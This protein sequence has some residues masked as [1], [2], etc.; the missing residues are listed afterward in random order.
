[1]G[2]L[3]LILA[4]VVACAHLATPVANIFGQYAIEA[5]RI[6]F[7][8]SGF[9]MTMIL[10]ER[11]AYRSL[12]NFYVSRALKLLPLYWAVSL[13]A[14]LAYAILVPREVPDHP[15]TQW[16]RFDIFAAPLS[17]LYTVI[18]LVTLIGAD[19]WVWLGFNP[20]NGRLSVA[21]DY[22]T[23]MTSVLGLG[24]VPQAWTIGLELCFYVMAPFVV[25]RSLRLLC[26]LLVASLLCRAAI[27]VCGAGPPW[28]RSLFPAELAF[29]LAGALLYRVTVVR[30][31]LKTSGPIDAALGALSYP[32]YIAHHAVFRVLATLPWLDRL[33]GTWGWL[34]INL[35]VVA[36]IAVILDALVARPVDRLRARFGA[37]ISD[38]QTANRIGWEGHFREKTEVNSSRNLSKL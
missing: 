6:F 21:P 34:A 31:I 38:P 26:L 3:R 5:V 14:L 32:I 22:G 16:E 9:Y 20:T 27:T 28:T 8:I 17:V 24:F 29:F 1:M 12:R 25:R 18:S 30:N 19:T 23:G 2:S 36:A 33:Q 11:K 37:S 13:L 15:F 10:I 35:A 7:V 4:L